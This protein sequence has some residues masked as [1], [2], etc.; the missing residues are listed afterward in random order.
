MSLTKIVLNGNQNCN[1]IWVKSGTLSDAEIN[2]VVDVYF[3][4]EDAPESA[5]TL[6][7]AKFN[8]SLEAGNYSTGGEAIVGWDIYKQ[9]DGASNLQFVGAVS[10]SQSGIVDCLVENGQEYTYY[11]FPQGL[12]TMG[13][14]IVSDPVSSIA[15][16]WV[17]FTA[18]ESDSKNLLIVKRAYIFQ[19]NVET[20][21]ISNNAQSNVMQNFT[22]YPKII[23]GTQNY[24]TGKLSA[25]V[26]YVDT[27]GNTYTETAALREAIM[28]LSTSQDRMFLKNRAGDMWEVSVH[29]PVS[30]SVKD[31]SPNQPHTASIEWTEV[32]TT[33]G[34][35][36]IGESGV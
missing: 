34:I 27:N 25:L 5:N 17:L 23:K 8:D 1:F 33:N 7:F 11:L 31:I 24:R 20:G 10:T 14:P 21:S 4:D 29:E 16:N 6:L 30:L 9:R 19:G 18:E 12:S 32:G 22:A 28:D 36:L 26:G 35:S 13:S 15:W 3:R 2:E